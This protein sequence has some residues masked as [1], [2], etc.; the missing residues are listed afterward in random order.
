MDHKYTV[1]TFWADVAT[2]M[3]VATHN[4]DDCADG[5]CTLCKKA[6][7]DK[8]DHV[9]RILNLFMSEREE[10]DNEELSQIGGC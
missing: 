5:A 9:I 3:Y 8:L 6:I 7:I 10:Y 4:V 1:T 2:E